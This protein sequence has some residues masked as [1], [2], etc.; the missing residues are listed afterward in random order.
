MPRLLPD[1]AR[2]LQLWKICHQY[3]RDGSTGQLLGAFVLDLCRGYGETRRTFELILA[4]EGVLW[5]ILQE[6]RDRQRKAD[7]SGGEPVLE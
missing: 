7:Q 6:K 4:L 2:P 1:N 5:P 3:G